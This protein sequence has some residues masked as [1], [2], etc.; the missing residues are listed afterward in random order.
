MRVKRKKLFYSIEISN[1]IT[2]EFIDYSTE[3]QPL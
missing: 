3:V 1:I 2:F